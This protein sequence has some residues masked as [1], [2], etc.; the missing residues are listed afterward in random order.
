MKMITNKPIPDKYEDYLRA[1]VNEE[2]ILC[3]DESISTKGNLIYSM[4]IIGNEFMIIT[5]DYHALRV[6]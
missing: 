5:S 3:E 1:R 4:N 2:D 6:Y